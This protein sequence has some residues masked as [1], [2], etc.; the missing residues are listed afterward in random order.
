VLESSSKM[1]SKSSSMASVAKAKGS[2]K[3][4]E[5]SSGSAAPRLRRRAGGAREAAPAVD[6]EVARK[7]LRLVREGAVDSLS[8]S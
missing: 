2:R 4:K 7:E 3:P 6:A 8:I 1:A 5:N